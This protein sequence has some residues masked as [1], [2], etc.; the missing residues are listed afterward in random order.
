MN[1]RKKY[2]IS[3]DG[4]D[5]D[6]A[7]MMFDYYQSL[8]KDQLTGKLGGQEAVNSAAPKFDD[9]LRQA[10]KCVSDDLRR[11]NSLN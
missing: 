3:I 9:I 7:D 8:P 2:D 1:S 11:G 4:Q 10:E 6:V 5:D